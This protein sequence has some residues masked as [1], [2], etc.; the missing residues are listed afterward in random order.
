MGSSPKKLRLGMGEGDPAAASSKGKDEAPTLDD[1][2][3]DASGDGSSRASSDFSS[4]SEAHDFQD[5][6][7]APPLSKR[8]KMG[9][10][11]RKV[12]EVHHDTNG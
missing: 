11:K 6:D 5:P 2:L 4:M 8:S 12:L 3:S 9:R 10:G 1:M 7:L